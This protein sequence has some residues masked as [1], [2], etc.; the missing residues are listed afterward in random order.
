MNRRVSQL[1]Q[2]AVLSGSLC[3][4]GGSSG[5]SPPPPPAE[6]RPFELGF[7]PWPYDATA[8]AVNFVYSEVALRGDFIAHHL[9]GGIPWEEALNG[10]P[11]SA[12]LEAEIGARLANTPPNMRTYLALSPLNGPRQGLADYWG[13]A[14]NQA[15]PSAWDSLALDDPDVI[16]AYTN[17]AA[18]LIRRFSPDY[19]NL[20]IEVSE[21]ALNDS[22]A[23]DELVR[24]TAAVSGSLSAQFPNVQL[25]ASVALKH[26]GSSAAAT[27]RTELP[28]LI[29]HVDVVGISVYP[30][31]F[32]DH[33]DRGD[34]ANLPT[35]WLSQVTQLAGGR[36]VAI[37]ETGWPAETLTIP[38]FGVDIASDS[39]KQNAY[40]NALFNAADA[41]DAVFIVWFSLVDYDALWNGALQR[42]PVAQ[43]WR[44]TGLYDEN[45]NTR[46]ALDTWMNQLALPIE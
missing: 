12:E 35:D 41:L 8:T 16:A 37:A 42:D 20:G 25:M 38:S 11:Y 31:V 4:C 46:P 17:F 5:G 9:D 13:T 22:A 36:P 19:F 2:L 1:L 45:L 27:I 24:F 43:I 10:M 29:Q 26:P 40:L 44:D 15:L 18:D 34:P 28:R 39:A 7:T 33:P 3:A 21:L 30:Y 32:F 14:P 23:Y 6:V